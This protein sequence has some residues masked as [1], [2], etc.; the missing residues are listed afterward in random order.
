M[1][2]EDNLGNLFP[3]STVV[4][5]RNPTQGPRAWWK[6]VPLNDEPPASLLLRFI[7]SP[8]SIRQLLRTHSVYRL[9]LGDEQIM[10]AVS[11]IPSYSETVSVGGP[12]PGRNTGGKQVE[13]K[14]VCLGSQLRALRCLGVWT[15]C[16]C[17]CGK[18]DHDGR[19]VVGEAGK[20]G[21]REEGRRS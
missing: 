6:F 8:P 9:G 7:L 15:C 1:K 2:L 13:R 10:S 19:C 5:P 20:Q 17:S 4:G 21:K 18:A 12:S 16:L 11:S 14:K 3:P